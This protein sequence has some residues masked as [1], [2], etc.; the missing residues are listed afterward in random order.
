MRRNHRGFSNFGMLQWKFLRI[1]AILLVAE[2]IQNLLNEI[3]GA[4]F[5]YFPAANKICEAC[6]AAK[7]DSDKLHTQEYAALKTMIIRHHLCS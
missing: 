2:K 4:L 7:D 3:R 1:N 6:N 5:K